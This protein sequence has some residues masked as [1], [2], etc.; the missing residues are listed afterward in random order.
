MTRK[1]TGA[2][3]IVIATLGPMALAACAGSDSQPQTP[4]PENIE[5]LASRLSVMTLVVA[6]AREGRGAFDNFLPCVRRGV[7]NYHNTEAGRQAT[8]SDCD[9][10]SGV[11]VHGDGEL[12]WVGPDLSTDRQTISRISWTGGLIAIVDDNIEVQI[13]EFEIDAIEMEIDFKRDFPGRLLLDSLTVRLLGETVRVEDNI[14]PSRI[15]DTSAMDIDSIPSHSNSLSAL[16]ESDMKRL[17]YNEVAPWILFLINEGLE[18]QRGNHTHEG[19]C[20]TSVVTQNLEDGTTRIDNTLGQCDFTGSGLFIDGTFSLEGTFLDES[21]AI[22]IEGVLTI[23]GGV[24]KTT[25]RK[26]E[27]SIENL[28]SSPTGPGQSLISGKVYG[29]T[30]DRSF[31]FDLIVDD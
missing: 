8:F 19:P 29:E 18:S 12:K 25:I 24:P 20:S 27:W 15:F 2:L 4:S 6:V 14:L 26:L 11:T 5:R 16:T 7:I 3:L 13:N 23:G 21:V 22:I 28:D 17:A 1:G 10:G 31:S 30:D 9:L